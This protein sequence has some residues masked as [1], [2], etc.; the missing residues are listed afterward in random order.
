[1]DMDGSSIDKKRIAKYFLNSAGSY[2]QHARIQEVLADNLLRLLLLHGKGRYR[3][4]LEVGCCTG[5]LTRKLFE[6][7]DVETLFLNDLVAQ[8]EPIVMAK[9]DTDKREKIVPLFGDIEGLSIPDKLD[10]CISSSTIQWLAQP[11]RFFEQITARTV[12]G[13]LLAISFFI[14]GTLKEMKEITRVGLRYMEPE[15]LRQSLEQQYE[16]LSFETNLKKLYFPDGRDVLR[17]VKNTGVGGISPY[18]WTK[19][20]LLEFEE[21]YM[22]KFATDQGCPVSYNNVTIIARKR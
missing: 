16:L 1:M 17:H 12:P 22:A 20:S 8:F 19:K 9:L 13:G 5:L 4:V 10:L 15:V 11:V 7:L 2:D 21:E 3:R 14:E 18:R 6:R